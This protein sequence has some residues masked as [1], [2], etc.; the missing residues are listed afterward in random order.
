M[1]TVNKIC[2]VA[3]IFSLALS[4]S[5]EEM[6]EVLT[7]ADPETVDGSL[8]FDFT[9]DS[10]I[11]EA[12]A[13]GLN[14]FNTPGRIQ[15]DAA[16]VNCH[17]PDG[18][19]LAFFDFKREDIIRRAEPHITLAEANDIADMVDALRKKY[20]IQN[21]KDPRAH[22]L[23]QPGGVVLPGDT[24]SDRDFTFLNV[25]LRKWV[26]TLFNEKVDNEATALKIRDEIASINLQ[27]MQIGIPLP[28]WAGDS[29]H[30]D[31]FGTVD[32]W[33]PNIPCLDS[34]PE[35]KQ[36][37]AN[38]I[39]YPSRNN[40]KALIRAIRTY[41]DCEDGSIDKGKGSMGKI[42]AR[43]K[44][45]SGLLAMHL[46][47]EELFGIQHS[48]DGDFVLSWWDQKPKNDHRF[49][50]STPN[51]FIWGIGD[52]GRKPGPDQGLKSGKYEKNSGQEFLETAGF[53]EFSIQ[54]QT[55]G[56]S[57]FYLQNDLQSSWFW[58]N[59]TFDSRRHT[60]YSRLAF[61]RSGY[62]G[63][64]LIKSY[65]DTYKSNFGPFS[66]S[67]HRAFH[68]RG[69]TK[70][71]NNLKKY[72][73]NYEAPS[74]YVERYDFVQTQLAWTML[75]V[76]KNWLDDPDRFEIKKNDD[77]RGMARI[78][79]FLWREKGE[80]AAYDWYYK[81]GPLVAQYVTNDKMKELGTKGYLDW[82]LD[83]PHTGGPGELREG[84]GHGR[85]S[86]EDYEEYEWE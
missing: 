22:R 16:C 85:I 54:G 33:M 70:G 79:N 84:H 25:E 19:D 74:G 63:H 57:K 5:D 24:R 51:N 65:F 76:T 26:P 69:Y 47:R 72:A 29:F 23:F 34:D 18:F 44:Y 27:K 1:E 81:Y 7:D 78:T 32:E 86:G 73:A 52:K 31:E 49:R 9:T 59:G 36:Q 21:P 15:S 38:Y 6:P 37:R 42:V 12:I 83:D 77:L 3:L 41:T 82:T 8:S 40:L 80:Q 58:L 68:P 10:Q 50:M 55:D 56:I 11:E 53:S 2:L 17:T 64:A 62:A 48:E 13:R 4:C 67:G 60:G 28:R 20:K 45:I 39:N 35:V 46:K 43:N 14:A 30:G 66:Y 75:Y 61:S 71:L